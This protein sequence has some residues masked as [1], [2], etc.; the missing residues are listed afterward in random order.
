[1]ARSH[2]SP[3]YRRVVATL[4]ALGS[5]GLLAVGCASDGRSLNPPP[6]APA[7]PAVGGTTAPGAPMR[8]TSPDFTEG[9]ALPVTATQDGGGLSPAL[10]WSS[11]P[12]DVVELA[13]TATRSDTGAVLWV[14]V[15]LDPRSRIALGTLPGGSVALRNDLGVAG[16]SAPSATGAPYSVRFTLFA[17]T[18]KLVIASSLTGQSAV[19]AIAQSASTQATL[20]ATVSPQPGLGTNR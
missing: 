11:V 13:V 15:G 4:V 17:S 6:P 9:G 10:S 2:C 20:T 5:F 1:M 3:P 19:N 7:P 8:L 12:A 14:V 18:R 16:W